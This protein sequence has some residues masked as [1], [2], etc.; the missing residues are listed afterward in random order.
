MKVLI[1]LESQSSV[2]TGLVPADLALVLCPLRP[3]HREP[4]LVPA[5]TLPLARLSSPSPPDPILFPLIHAW[6]RPSLPLGRC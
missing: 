3:S 6:Q 4:L 2:P 5:S 1:P